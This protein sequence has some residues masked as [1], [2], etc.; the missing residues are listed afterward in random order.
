M[1]IFNFLNCGRINFSTFLM[2]A[3]G[4]DG[5]A[6]DVDDNDGKEGKD[7]RII[8]FVQFQARNFRTK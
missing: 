3:Q 1:E 7:K 8:H 2:F 4:G 5:P 6:K